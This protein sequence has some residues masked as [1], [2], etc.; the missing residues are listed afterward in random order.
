MS[1][2]SI[3]VAILFIIII[4]YWLLYPYRVIEFEQVPYP[5]VNENKT[6]R[7]G[8]LL[9]YEVEYCK[10]MNIGATTTKSFNNGIIYSLPPMQSNRETGCHDNKIFL[11]VPKTLPPAEYSLEVLYRFQ[12]NPIR[13]IEYKQSTEPFTVIR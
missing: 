9:I 2:A 13:V 1:Y 10:F 3:F 5:I 11:E 12:V 6:V 8:E 7:Q 4:F